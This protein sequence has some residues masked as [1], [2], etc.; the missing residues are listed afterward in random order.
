MPEAMGRADG[1]RS[2]PSRR[3]D[4]SGGAISLWVVLMA[5]VAVFAAVV[6]MAGPQRMAAESSLEEAANDV[7]VLAVTLRDGRSVP[8]GEIEGFLPDCPALVPGDPNNPDE[9]R[10]SGEMKEVCKLLLGDETGSGGA[11]LHRDLGY[12]GIDTVF[13][14]GF[15]S[16][17]L[18][19][20]NARGPDWPHVSSC[21]VSGGLETRNAVYV[22]LA[23][24]WESGGWAAA[25]SWPDGE[26]LGAE[27]VARLNQERLP[28]TPPDCKPEELSPPPSSDPPRTVF[29]D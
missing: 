7:A 14:E 11:Y 9:V 29:S 6:A 13:W 27:V 22:A 1:G 26:R 24:D 28:G 12:L 3:L 8:A 16:D 5:P 4:Q 2:S 20:H 23:A 10:Q 15:Y 17:S 25:Q 19:P 18:D 21:L